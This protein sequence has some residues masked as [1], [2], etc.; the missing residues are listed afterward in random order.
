MRTVLAVITIAICL[1]SSKA[2]EQQR[3][4]KNWPCSNNFPIMKTDRN[5]PIRLSTDDAIKR[6]LHCEAPVW[7]EIAR[8]AARI[9]G[10][11]VV[12]IAVAPNGRVS[13][14]RTLTGHPILN[15]SALEAAKRWVFRPMEHHGKNVGFLAVLI[16][17]Y[18]TDDTDDPL[19]HD[20][21]KAR[22]N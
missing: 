1:S 18:S 9:K 5:E 20:C 2:Q 7:P 22:W 4:E 8:R 13:C 21:T 15:V 17:S 19:K 6:A 11:V 14:T 10:T 3:I 16:F 12:E